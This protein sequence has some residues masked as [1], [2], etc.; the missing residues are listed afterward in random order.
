[1]AE[2]RFSSYDGDREKK[3]LY[4]RGSCCYLGTL[5]LKAT[6]LYGVLENERSDGEAGNKAGS[7]SL[8]GCI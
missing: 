3:V 5:G 8:L 2:S 7:I 1:M 6:L 4:N